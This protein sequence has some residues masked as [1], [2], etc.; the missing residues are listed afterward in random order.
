M[1]QIQQFLIILF[2]FPLSLT[3]QSPIFAPIGAVWRYNASDDNGLGSRHYRYVVTADTV[4][5]GWDARIMQGEI[6]NGT[7]F[8]PSPV[9]TRYVST[10]ADQVYH[11]VDTSFVLLMDFS[12]QPGDTIHSA[13]SGIFPFWNNCYN[14]PSEREDFYYIIE[15]TG[16]EE[17]SGVVLRKQ[18]IIQP[19]WEWGDWNILG[20]FGG[21]GKITER[22]GPNPSGT[23]FGGNRTCI[24]E[25]PASLRCYT[26][27]E[28][29]FEGWTDGLPC[30][31]VL[32]TQTP[33]SAILSV[34]PN[35]FSENII[36]DIPDSSH[37]PVQ[38]RLF[39]S[40]GRLVVNQE[41]AAGRSAI[42]AGNLPIGFYFWEIR[43]GIRLWDSGKLV[44]G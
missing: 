1:K 10:T 13:V 28:I 38:F 32:S 39:D 23:W 37:Q 5:N 44:K 27:N 22:I 7:A 24:Q 26:D 8:V 12:A 41:V 15:S 16:M 34:S 3:A 25:P 42:P 11:W 4:I 14:P 18:Q 35:P 9:M 31:T 29:F 20:I 40:T 36:L 43:Q 21:S 33:P 2:L 19:W 30:D 6:W 17:I